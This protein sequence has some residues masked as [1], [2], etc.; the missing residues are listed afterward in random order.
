MTGTIVSNPTAVNDH[1][2]PV[3]P[4]SLPDLPRQDDPA[5]QTAVSAFQKKQRWFDGAR[6]PAWLIS[7]ILHTIALIV[8]ALVSYGGRR[9]DNGIAIEARRGAPSHAVSFEVAKSKAQAAD[10]KDRNADQPVNVTVQWNQSQTLVQSPT[11]ERVATPALTNSQ[12]ALITAGGQ[13]K[14][15]LMQLPGGG[16]AGRTPEG[17][18]KYGDLFGATQQSESAVELALKW[19]AEHQ[20]PDGSWSF[21]L[22]LDP[23]DGRCKNSKDAGDT[24]TPATGATGL[25]LLAFLGAGYTHQTGPYADTVRRG[26]Y[27]L[28]NV[29]GESQFGYDWQQGSMYG[30]GI[31]VMALSE[32]L[33]MTTTEDGKYDSD[34]YQLVQRGAD[35]TEV[36][37]HANGSWGYVPGSPGDTTLTGW[38][39]LSLVAARRNG[40]VL[41]TNTL[42]KAKGFI[43]DVAGNDKFEFGYK[44]MPGEPTTT[45]IGLTLLLYLGET[46]GITH[47]DR[48]FDRIAVRGPTL[49][50]VYHDYYATLALHHVRHQD[51]ERWNAKLRD[52]L[53][54]TQ[55]KLGHEAGS[56]HFQDK[57]GDIGGRLYTTAMCTMILGVYYRYLP[58][59]GEIA[60]FPL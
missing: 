53:V 55:S 60:E 31:A 22:E 7:T 10:P 1:A 11:A 47:F 27:Y 17:R 36:A 58:L 5:S 41:R 38:Q 46:P 43:R 50:N 35:F 26:I 13:S 25:A 19:L 52:H 9:K 30:H 48:Q 42:R 59:Y 33:A 6:I 14:S 44:G 24:P 21:N 12:I 8:L 40:V 45:A 29:A 37:Q 28:R 2:P 18:T 34:L 20:R 56:W 4:P 54:A 57:W 23:C 15:K 49:T 32:A 39:V 51:W 16:L 3:P